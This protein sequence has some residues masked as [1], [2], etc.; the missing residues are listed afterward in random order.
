MAKADKKKK[1]LV[2]RTIVLL[3]LVS[4]VVYTIAMRDKVKVLAVGD[5]APDFE[6]VD[7]DGN[8]HRLSDYRGEGVF[9]NFWGTW[10]GPCKKEMPYMEKLHNEFEGRG[11]NILA[12]NI[13]E[14]DLKVETFRDQYG[15]TFPI[16]I[17]KTGSV[18]EAYNIIPLPATFLINKDGRIE[19]IITREMSEHE[20]RSF[21][22]SIKPE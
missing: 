12:I 19:Q 16:A 4:A 1:R 20:I 22:E 6:L 13:K 21:M 18:K 17:D 3:L 14:S 11:V 2:I 10:C 5:I 8:K 9:L 15:L 7:L